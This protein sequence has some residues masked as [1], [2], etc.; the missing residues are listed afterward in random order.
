VLGGSELITIWRGVHLGREGDRRPIRGRDMVFLDM[1][2]RRGYWRMLGLMERR[3]T[4]AFSMTWEVPAEVYGVMTKDFSV[5]IVRIC[6][7]FLA[8][9][10]TRYT[11]TDT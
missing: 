1:E 2:A 6:E 7:S 4:W 11:W 3:S 10:G 9:S 8:R 5:V